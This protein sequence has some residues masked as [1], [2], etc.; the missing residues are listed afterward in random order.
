MIK[1][2]PDRYDLRLFARHPRQIPPP[3]HHLLHKRLLRGQHE[4]DLRQHPAHRP[5]EQRLPVGGH[6]ERPPDRPRHLGHVRVGCA[7]STPDARQ[8]PLRLQPERFLAG[9]L[10]LRHVEEGVGRGEV[11]L[12]EDLGARGAEGVLR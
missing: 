2:S 8:E 4:Q 3:L 1:L 12:R 10:R 5:E 9:H 6:L 7:Q 11:R